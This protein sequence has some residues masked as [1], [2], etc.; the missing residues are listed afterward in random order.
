MTG[1]A[2]PCGP[3]KLLADFRED[4]A[5][6]DEV[7]ERHRRRNA[8]ERARADAVPQEPVDADEAAI[9]ATAT[10]AGAVANIIVNQ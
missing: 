3:R 9:A 7:L 10:I 5:A 4:W 6:A 8:R 2:R 1:R